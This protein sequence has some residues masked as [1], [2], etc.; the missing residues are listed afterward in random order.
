MAQFGM[1]VPVVGTGGVGLGSGGSLGA[2]KPGPRK[3][4]G[5]QGCWQ[6]KSQLRVQIWVLQKMAATQPCTCA[7]LSVSILNV[8]E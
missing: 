6:P 5:K 7:E 1:G 3:Q 2:H 4:G 8:A